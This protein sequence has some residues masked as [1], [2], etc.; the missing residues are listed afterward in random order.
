MLQLYNLGWLVS[1]GSHAGMVLRNG[2]VDALLHHSGD[3]T[4]QDQ[5]APQFLVL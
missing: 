3:D 4:P 1:T 2:S 5:G